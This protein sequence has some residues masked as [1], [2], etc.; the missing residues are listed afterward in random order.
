MA[1]TYNYGAAPTYVKIASQT[2]TGTPVNV[3]FSNIPQG[4]TDL[5]I[6]VVSA[7]PTAGNADLRIQFNSDSTSN[8]S[9]TWLRGNGSA[10]TSG[11]ETSQTS[12]MVGWTDTTLITNT[13]IHLL[14]YSNSYTYKT[15]LSRNNNIATS[16]VNTMVGLW[17]STAPITSITLI[18]VSGYSFSAGSTVNIYGIKAATTAPKATGGD[19]VTTDGYYWYHTFK[20]TATLIPTSALTADVMVIAGGGGGLIAGGGA[21]GLRVLTGQSLAAYTSYTATIGAGGAAGSTSGVNSTFTGSGFTTISAT[22]GGIGSLNSAGVAGG[23]GGG[24]SNTNS[25]ARTGGAGNA[26]GYTPVE[27]Y[28]GGNSASATGYFGAGGGGAGGVGTN[29][30]SSA[31]GAGGVGSS[32]YQGWGAAT[33]TGQLVSGV[34]YYA[35]GGGGA[36]QAGGGKSGG[37]GGGGQGER[38]FEVGNFIQNALPNMGGGGGGGYFIAHGAGGSGLIIVRYPV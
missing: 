13:I 11:R 2:V 30:T 3:A 1:V 31:S 19:T 37:Y 15:I 23:S 16:Y 25:T 12:A 29:S 32:A 10:A 33:K 28:A 20:N 36:D 17:R 4:Y 26:G 7:N 24:T 9:E 27:G 14:N 21:G 38:T 6:S 22:G 5:V 34:Y 35:G 8:Y 18:N